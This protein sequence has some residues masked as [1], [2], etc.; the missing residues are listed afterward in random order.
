VAER[1][2]RNHHSLNS[3]H[4]PNLIQESR[5]SRPISL[6]LDDVPNSKYEKNTSPK[7]TDE[8]QVQNTP[9]FLENTCENT[10]SRIRRRGN[11]KGITQI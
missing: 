4:E 10:S 11:S 6:D 9:P 8:E 1:R 7:E 3:G 2:S 5:Q